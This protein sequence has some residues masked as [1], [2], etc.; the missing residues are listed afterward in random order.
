[1][2]NKDFSSLL[3]IEKHP[4]R[5]QGRFREIFSVIKKRIDA[6]I[7]RQLELE[8]QKQEIDRQ[9]KQLEIENNEDSELVE[10]LAE[11]IDLILGS[12]GQLKFDFS[13]SGDETP[14]NR[15]KKPA[16][17]A[18]GEWVK[19]DDISWSE[20]VLK[21]IEEADNWMR[22]SEI[23]DQIG[24]TQSAKNNYRESI[25]SQLNNL[26]GTKILGIPAFRKTKS[27]YAKTFF[28][29]LPAFFETPEKER[30]YRAKL[31]EKTQAEGYLLEIPNEG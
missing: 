5:F 2:E 29:G 19:P 23:A 21:A 11:H 8:H 12:S 1:M 31:E 9:I 26:R 27:G 24:M 18:T 10:S 28:N 3:A 15:T 30:I 16:G 22:Y 6:R 13:E 25:T 4:S 7:V 17:L 14:V 20:L